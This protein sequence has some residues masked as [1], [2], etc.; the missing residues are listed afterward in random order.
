[1][2]RAAEFEPRLVLSQ[3]RP[4]REIELESGEGEPLEDPPG[5]VVVHGNPE[6]NILPTL[7]SFSARQL[8][9]LAVATLLPR[10]LLA[11]LLGI[12]G[13]PERW[14]YDVIA[15]NIVSGSGH[16]YDRLGF[17]YAAYAPPLWSYLLALLTAP[18]GEARGAIQVAQAFLCFGAATIYG[19]LARMISGHA[20]TGL[21]AAFLVALQPSLLYYSVVKSDPLPLN[22]LL[23]GLIVI[24]GIG[25]ATRP[26]DRRAAAFGL[27]VGLGVLSRGTPIVIL[28]IVAGAL[29]FRFGSKAL[30]PV[31]VTTIAFTLCLAPWLIRNFLR[32]GASVITTTTGEN[33]WRGN[34][35]GA[36]GGVRDD[37][38]GEISRLL[39]S[40]E[41]L[42]EVIRRVLAEGSE[43]ERDKVFASE[44]WRFIR[45]H[46]AGAAA[47]FARKLRTFWWRLDSDPRDYSRASV[48]AYEAIYRLELGLA[49][50]GMLLGART[51][52]GP[53]E[54]PERW[55]GF[56]VFAALIAMSLLQCAFY[57][58]G[59][60][61]FLIEPLLLI[62]TALG[63]A[64]L[65]RATRLPGDFGREP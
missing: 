35:E 13:A 31:G 59:R 37:D 21:V 23:V 38:G 36:T 43:M 33:F 6:G 2:A 54:A 10:A 9:L 12:V 55:P 63:L 39:P 57:V 15:A 41:D 17:V 46:P 28:P 58:Q 8:G 56:V 3:L 24:T 18:F 20:R 22:V 65:A 62:F 14:E 60:H 5:K 42:P 47:L 32:L 4:D 1:M 26:T 29:L 44:S 11:A 51:L 7:A 19:S 27:L 49:L 45:S 61:R 50:V 52:P 40:N 25:V 48:I 30:R 16:L 53:S 64:A 34:H